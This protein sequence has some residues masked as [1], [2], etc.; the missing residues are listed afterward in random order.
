MLTTT[1]VR[2]L[3]PGP[4]GPVAEQLA[5]FERDPFG[6]VER[7]A[8]RYGDM[9]TL[10]LGAL[11]NEDLT[12]VEHNGH[13]VF[14]TR[15]DQLK[16]MYGSDDRT[17]GA[18]ANKV[19]FGTEEES[20]GYIDGTMHRRRRAQL[21]PAFSGSRDYA[22]ITANAVD[23]HVARWPRGVPFD[24]FTALQALTSDIIVEV[25]CGGMDAEDKAALAALLLPME[26][27]GCGREE[28]L[29]AD[30]AVRAFVDERLPGHLDR[31]AEAGVDDVFAALL[32]HAAEGDGSLT[33]EVVR[34]EVFSLLYTG[35]STTANTLSW[36]FLHVLDD[37]RVR[38]KLGRELGDRFRSRPVR[39]QDFRGLDYLDATLMEALRLHP[40]SALNG[41]RMVVSP[42]RIDD[43]ELPPGTFLVHCAYLLQRDPDLYPDPSLFRPERFVDASVDPYV[44][45]AFGGGSRTCVG[46]G[47]ARAEMRM[48]LAMVLSSVRMRAAGPIPAAR[49]QGIFMAPE[50]TRCVVEE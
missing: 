9:F 32:R 18:L 2:R 16:V 26:N 19:F 15:P 49:Q 5:A 28:I 31:C 40:V 44:W 1:P 47:Y 50:R 24:L 36:T 27:A 35:F 42:M 29:E 10:R 33:D 38:A 41:V 17:S 4:D 34:D 8:R 20:V 11:G 3:P 39:A 48:I 6:C 12:A 43:Y 13:W 7:T 23:A 46:R 14:L 37:D 21:H 30:R 45:G 22:A 25:V